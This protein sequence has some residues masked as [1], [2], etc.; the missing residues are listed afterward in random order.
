MKPTIW[1]AIAGSLFLVIL[2]LWASTTISDSRI[3]AAYRE[4]IRLARLDGIPTTAGEFEATIPTVLP[5][6][7]AAP[8]YRRLKSL[9]A[10]GE[11]A[12][13]LAG[14]LV[15]KPSAKTLAEAQT[16]LK[17][18]QR[19][20]KIIDKAALKPRCWFDRD[21][22]QGPVVLLPELSEMKAAA[23]LLGLRGSIA[24]AKGDP[25]AALR[26]ATLIFRISAHAGEDPTQVG[27]LC[28]EAIFLTGAQR[29]AGWAV[30]HRDTPAYRVALQRAV[31]RYPMPDSRKEHRKD[32]FMMLW[33]IDHGSTPAGGKMM[34]LREKDI[35]P[36]IFAQSLLANG[37]Q[38]RLD[39]VKAERDYWDAF[40]LPR[41]EGAKRQERDMA[42]TE[43]A[44]GAFPYAA[45]LFQEF[46]VGEPSPT[47]RE[48]LS[49]AHRQTILAAARA[50]SEPKLPSRI[51][52]RDLRS[53]FDGKPLQYNYDGKQITI[54]VS[55]IVKDLGK[56]IE[57][58]IPPDYVLHP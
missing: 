11:K 4:Q 10:Q 21:W 35:P 1:L 43:A 18:N 28:R 24:A 57:L 14:K 7:N 52:T 38:S 6:E 20:L 29:I 2:G 41:E 19:S 30:A 31:L 25:A 56:Q 47:E 8:L 55:G 48:N 46:Y 42:I 23:R 49:I 44:I 15:F 53:P 33:L 3:E 34:G 54:K 32:L 27:G 51:A 45:T 16:L 13:K 40:S 36:A 58:K 26:D 9:D 5:S 39:I 22:S 50:I 17:A 37:P 12:Q